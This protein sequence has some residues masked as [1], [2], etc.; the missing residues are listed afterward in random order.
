MQK[1]WARVCAMPRPVAA[2]FPILPRLAATHQ[3]ATVHIFVNSLFSAS[4]LDS[5]KLFWR[6]NSTAR[7]LYM[8]SSLFC[9]LLWL[10]AAALPEVAAAGQCR[11]FPGDPCWPTP[12]EWSA[13]NAS[14]DGRLIATIPLA[15]PCHDPQ[16]DAA[17]CDRLRQNWLLPQE[18]YVLVSY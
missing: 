7:S 13:F 18:Q 16:F 5:A 11:C 14:I 9:G 17:V 2:D 4:D 8:P 10:L 3:Q 6:S 15:A 12:S 1:L